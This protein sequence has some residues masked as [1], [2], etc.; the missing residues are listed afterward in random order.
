LKHKGISERITLEKIEGAFMSDDSD[1]KEFS[2]IAIILIVVLVSVSAVCITLYVYYTLELWNDTT[3]F[4]GIL[5]TVFTGIL[6][7]CTAIYVFFTFKLLRET[8]RSNEDSKKSN[9]NSRKLFILTRLYEK[10][11]NSPDYLENIDKLINHILSDDIKGME[12]QLRDGIKLTPE[13]IILEGVSDE[14]E[15][16]VKN[17]KLQEAEILSRNQLMNKSPLDIRNFV[18]VLLSYKE[19]EKT[20]E[21]GEYLSKENISE[22]S[23]YR[24]CGC[25]FFEFEN[26]ES[27]IEISE[28]GIE[29]G[30]DSEDDKSSI[31]QN[32][33]YFYATRMNKADEKKARE[34]AN[35]NYEERNTNK[36]K[37]ELSRDKY[38][39]AKDT[40]GYVKIRY[41]KN[42][43]EVY[44]GLDLCFEAFKEAKYNTDIKKY[45]DRAQKDK[46]EKLE[47]LKAT[48]FM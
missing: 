28:I 32:L 45:F 41:A 40:L 10:H 33:A 5:L 26:I 30:N 39:G 36:D 37:D 4:M 21:A 19:R 27:A 11:K 1:K 18:Y 20:S 24:E 35:K 42:E 25:Q 17:G 48:S 6:A 23:L 47:E 29:K 22:T 44:E 14:I 34:Y 43:A 9:E 38:L 16:L 8:V 46:D 13:K 15:E 3:K 31:I 7:A 12:Q 2:S